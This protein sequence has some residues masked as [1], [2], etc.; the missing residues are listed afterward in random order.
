[1]SE[2]DHT[3][4]PVSPTGHEWPCPGFY[5]T[6]SVKDR[7][8]RCTCVTPTT[9]QVRLATGFK[10]SIQVERFDRW[11][12]EVERA[13]AA[14]ALEEAADRI[15]AGADRQTKHTIALTLRARAAEI[16]EGES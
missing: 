8:E 4:N 15:K 10:H 2:Y 3:L 16:R 5:R 9:E 6:S 1:M 14:R 7:T 12:A 11:L 13:A